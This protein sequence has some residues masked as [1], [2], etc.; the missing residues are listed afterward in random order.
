[1]WQFLLE[2]LCT[3]RLHG[4]HLLHHTLQQHQQLQHHDHQQQVSV[5]VPP[6]VWEGGYGEFRV[7]DPNRL[8][9]LWGERKR[10]P[11]MNYDK[12]TRALRYYYDKHI[13]VKVPGRPYCYRFN[14][15]GLLSKGYTL[16]SVVNRQFSTFIPSLMGAL[17]PAPAPA[18]PPVFSQAVSIGD[19]SCP[20]QY[21][22]SPFCRIQGR[23]TRFLAGR[24]INRTPSGYADSYYPSF[25]YA[26]T[27]QQ[28]HTS[29]H[30]RC[31]SYSHD[32]QHLNASRVNPSI[33]Y[34][35]GG[36]QVLSSVNGVYPSVTPHGIS[37]D[38]HSLSNYLRL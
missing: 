35:T 24:R 32:Y 3:Y 17:V 36:H 7:V 12:L 10:R 9:Q 15:L 31:P 16:P 33:D 14:F 23:P 22:S 38:R 30:S 34:S 37:Y 13:M 26:R 20:N 1:M 21:S 19:Y 5:S 27:Q 8:A 4:N 29:T 6:V 11:N 18:N 28:A 25:P 2:L